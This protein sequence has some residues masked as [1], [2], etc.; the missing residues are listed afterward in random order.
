MCILMLDIKKLSGT[1]FLVVK[2]IVKSLFLPNFVLASS[3][4]SVRAENQHYRALLNHQS[5]E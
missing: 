5:H 2:N 4:Q 1:V 3:K